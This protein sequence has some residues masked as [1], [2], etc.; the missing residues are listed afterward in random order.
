MPEPFKNLLKK[1]VIE[2]MALHFKK[3]CSQFDEQAFVAMATDKLDDLELKKRTQQIT[4]AMIAYLPSDFKK[5]GA[6]ILASLAPVQDNQSLK[7]NTGL[8]G[9]QIMPVADYIGLQGYSNFDYAMMLFKEVTQRASAE[10]GIRYFIEK[11]SKKTLA[12][13][14]R[15]VNVDNQHVRRLVS[16][17]IRP[18]LP[19][20]TQLSEFIKDPT[21]VIALLDKLKDDP[22]EYVR[23]SVANNL[24]DIAKDH[25]ETVIK[26]ARSWLKGA[27]PERQKL[28]QH[29]CR[30]LIK[31]G[32]KNTLEILGYLPPDI[33]KS[34]F[35]I[36]NTEVDFGDA[37]EFTLTIQSNSS[38]T[39]KLMI[40][41]IIH[42]QKANGST[43]AK[44]FKGRNVTL[45]EHQIVEFRK[46][47]A[48]K[49]ITT[50]VYHAGQHKVEIMINGISMGSK[51][52]ILK[53]I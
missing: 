42:H 46:K 23:R 7:D 10:F 36:L 51:E 49:K 48:F 1:E 18:R 2:N 33:K 15:W 43:K 31:K 28:I 44:V 53:M 8:S 29:A 37:V 12:T 26:L 4:H 52:F 9:W 11:N 16:E 35:E 3:H 39:Q 19:W 5:A 27:S 20:A 14:S 38:R 47:H 6:I 17:G 50:R 30:T 41:Y 25:P 40:D 22:E 34:Q 32:D 21:P 45:K 24:N 13:L